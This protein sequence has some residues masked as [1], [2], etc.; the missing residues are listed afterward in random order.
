MDALELVSEKIKENQQLY[1]RMDKDARELVY[2]EPYK[3]L[4][5]FEKR[6]IPGTVSITMPDSAI[7]L[8]SVVSLI[9]NAK[10]QTFVEGDISSGKKTYIEKFNYDAFTEADE[11]RLRRGDKTAM[12][13]LAFHIC[14]RGWIGRRLVWQTDDNKL[15]LDDL[16]VDM[17]Y[18]PFETDNS[19]LVW[20]APTY[21][22]SRAA[23]EKLYPKYKSSSGNKLLKITDFWNSKINEVWVEDQKSAEEENKIGYPPFVITPSPS[24][25]VLFDKGYTKHEGESV[26][27]LGRDM[28]KP[29]NQIVSVDQTLAMMA[30]DP[31]YQLEVD[32]LNQEV[33]SPSASGGQVIKTIKGTKL[34][35]VPQPDIKMANRVAH[36]SIQS[37]IQKAGLSEVDVAQPPKVTSA[38]W[39]TEQT[40]LRNKLLVPLLDTLVDHCGQASRMSIDQYIKL[41]GDSLVGKRGK[42]S[43]YKA[44]QL[45]DLDDYTI[46]YRLMSK[47]RKQ[48]IAN[49]VVANAAKGTYSLRTIIEDICMVDD[50]ELELARIESEQAE[51]FDPVVKIIRLV[52]SLID[53]A[54][55]MHEEEAEQKYLE[56]RRLANKCFLLIKSETLPQTQNLLQQDKAQE[57]KQ[58]N[59][60]AMMG[61]SAMGNEN[62]TG[63][64]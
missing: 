3:L 55:N 62:L 54:D 61:V 45:K 47:S 34:D 60:N 8:N 64:V 1:I 44:S 6:E 43:K 29:W 53:Q 56:A 52:C 24:G 28:Y 27:F 35:L 58:S 23:V 41:D 32:N 33:E 51:Q 31:N 57:N 48:E 7:Y 40:E 22:R 39:I 9:L 14:A 12:Q 59:I 46:S 4:S 37:A 36:T 5:A 38:L 11:R 16:P 42:A 50:P 25:F 20:V 18:T 21:W 13:F 15:Y 19:G 49:T 2:L 17:R 63:G 10:W 26:F 30:V